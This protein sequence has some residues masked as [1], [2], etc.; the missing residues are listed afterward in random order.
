MGMRKMQ[1]VSAHLENLH[2]LDGKR[3]DKGSEGSPHCNY[4]I[5]RIRNYV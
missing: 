4:Y 5:E 1:G 3:R 2:S